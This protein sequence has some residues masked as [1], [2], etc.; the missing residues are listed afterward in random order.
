MQKVFVDGQHGTTGLEIQ[1]LLQPRPDITLL[2]LNEADRK[3]PAARRAYLNAADAVVLCL[4]DAAAIDAVRMIDSPTVRVLD[5]S[6]AHRV[7]AGW[8]YGMPELHGR[9]QRL[10]RATRVSNPGCFPTGFLFAVEPVSPAP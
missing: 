7:D 10:L 3:D 6:T 4:P 1:R 8:E 9:R 5:A 2:S